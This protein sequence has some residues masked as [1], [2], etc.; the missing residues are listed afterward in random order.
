MA[1]I[2]RALGIER[3]SAPGP[4]LYCS[5]GEIHRLPL[6][7]ASSA[8]GFSEPKKTPSKVKHVSNLETFQ[9]ACVCHPSRASISVAIT[10]CPGFQVNLAHGKKDYGCSPEVSDQ[11][12]QSLAI[13]VRVAC[14][15]CDT[16]M[17]VPMQPMEPSLREP[18]R[19]GCLKESQSSLCA[20]PGHR[21]LE[22]RNRSNHTKDVG[23]I[24]AEASTSRH[25]TGL[26]QPNTTLQGGN[27]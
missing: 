16:L 6:G 25:G 9:K 20:A 11:R 27:L 21:S 2:R 17:A 7:L 4:Y 5:Y 3:T 8:W 24:L 12:A 13:D 23:L 19:S 26:R 18:P 1:A 22:N 10:P 15:C 14:G